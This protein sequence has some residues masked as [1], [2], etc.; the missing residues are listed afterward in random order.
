MLVIGL[1]VL[2]IV[3]LAMA[4]AAADAPDKSMLYLGQTPPGAVPQLFA[5]GIVGTGMHTR[6]F[7]MTPDGREI[8]FHQ[9]SVVNG[10]FSKLEIGTRV[11]FVETMGEKGAQASTVK[12]M[13]KHSLR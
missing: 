2:V 11:Y 12:P 3:I 7:A 4:A 8:Y 9:N 1:V 10:A 13:G 6:D 5:P